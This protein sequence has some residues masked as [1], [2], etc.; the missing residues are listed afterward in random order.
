MDW[1][2]QQS[3]YVYL[4]ERLYNIHL[5]EIKCAQLTPWIPSDYHNTIV[6]R[7]ILPYLAEYARMVWPIFTNKCWRTCLLWCLQKCTKNGT[8]ENGTSAGVTVTHF[9]SDQ[10]GFCVKN[11][12]LFRRLEIL[13]QRIY[14]YVSRRNFK[15]ASKYYTKEYII[16]FPID[17]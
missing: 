2:Q 17:I 9:R 14:Y 3:D 4:P 16:I 15:E 10:S 1:N 8:N 13:Y 11:V 5:S 7:H 12:Y 6:S